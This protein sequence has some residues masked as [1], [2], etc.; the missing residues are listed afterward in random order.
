MRVARP[1]GRKHIPPCTPGSLFVPIWR[2]MRLKRRGWTNVI[3]GPRCGPRCRTRR[4]RRRRP[5]RRRRWVGPL[6]TGSSRLGARPTSLQLFLRLAPTS[7]RL[8]APAFYSKMGLE[9]SAARAI[10]S[11]PCAPSAEAS[12]ELLPSFLAAQGRARR[13]FAQSARGKLYGW[14]QDVV[15]EASS[16][17]VHASFQVYQDQKQAGVAMLVSYRPLALSQPSH[18]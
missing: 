5:S 8:L 16:G 4:R 17:V 12:K 3:P 6:A 1:S 10:C 18:F 15:V 2:P 7:R 14:R 9:A 13:A 11:T